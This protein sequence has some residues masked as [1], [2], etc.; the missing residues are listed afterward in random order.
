MAKKIICICLFYL[1]TLT[2][3]KDLKDMYNLVFPTAMKIDYQ[4]NQYVLSF[5]IINSNA[6]SKSEIES[7]FNQ[8]DILVIE[9]KGESLSQAIQVLESKMRVQIILSVVDSLFIT[10]NMLKEEQFNDLMDYFIIDPELRFTVSLFITDQEAKEL[11]KVKHNIT[12]SPYFSLVSYHSENRINVLYLPADFLTVMKNYKNQQTTSLIPN[13]SVSKE[14]S[15]LVEG[16]YQEQEQFNI[17]KITL[18]NNQKFITYPI[19]EVMGLQF[20][21]DKQIQ[22]LVLTF[23]QDDLQ[24]NYNIE[25]LTKKYYYQNHHYFIDLYPT[26]SFD[27]NRPNLNPNELKEKISENISQSIKETYLKL[28][29]SGIDFYHYE[30]M[31]NPITNDNLIVRVYPRIEAQTNY[32]N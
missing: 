7:S 30:R 28:L 29:A 19:D 11:F 5:K 10:E 4:D 12:S 27:V 16:E 2:G 3:C 14:A 32:T 8:G 24:I 1:F 25:S 22:N 26:I 23:K 13:M 21:S 15:L 6:L 20:L 9:T 31:D 17:E 18:L